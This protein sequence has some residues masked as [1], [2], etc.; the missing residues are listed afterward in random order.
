MSFRPFLISLLVILLPS[1]WIETIDFFDLFT[2]QF[3]F[4]YHRAHI[5]EG[6]WWLF[7]T[8]HFDHLGWNHLLLNAAFLILLLSLFEPLFRS[9]RVISITLCSMLMIS[10]MMWFFS[11]FLIWYVGL[12]GCL[13]SVLVYGVAKDERYPY[14]FRVFALSLIVAKVILEQLE[15]E[16]V[17]VSEFIS[18]PVAVDSHLYGLISGFAILVISNAYT[19]LKR[20]ISSQ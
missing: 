5:L 6:Q 18:G 2:G 13:Y 1:L 19:K 7:L 14:S 9:G 8:G 16:I 17:Q 3:D 12:S 10:S 15:F 20:R 11:P 4:R